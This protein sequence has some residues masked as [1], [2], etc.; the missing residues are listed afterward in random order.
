MA[1]PASTTVATVAVSGI[2]ILAL[3]PG[4][5]A[6]AVMGAFAGASVFVMS[7]NELSKA[8]KLAFL[9]LAVI[10]GLIATPITSAVLSKI[11]P[12]SLQVSTALGA[13]I[14][15]ALVI[16]VLIW[17][18]AK[19]DNPAALFQAMKGGDK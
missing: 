16:K 9:C 17:L 4:V 1:E 2:S 13:L 11:M 7:S 15:S 12:E 6:A 18:I 14:A 10:A 5:D 8:K 19:A 3:F